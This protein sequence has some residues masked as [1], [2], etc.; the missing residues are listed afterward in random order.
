MKTLSN[1]VKKLEVISKPGHPELRF[2]FFGGDGNSDEE[3]N[4]LWSR[5]KTANPK[6]VQYLNIVFVK[7]DGNGGV[8]R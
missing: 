5:N 8:L 4:R 2:R 7:S 6:N 3:L 1:R